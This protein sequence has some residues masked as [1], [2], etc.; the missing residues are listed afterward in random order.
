MFTTLDLCHSLLA[1]EVI[2]QHCG[3]T[4]TYTCTGS[5][6]R[7]LSRPQV[8]PVYDLQSPDDDFIQM[9]RPLD[10]VVM[11]AGLVEGLVKDCQRFLSSGAWYRQRGIPHRYLGGVGSILTS[12]T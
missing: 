11:E 8:T 5:D 10:S 12:I 6:W 9:S 4:T 3:L 1:Q 2:S 7:E